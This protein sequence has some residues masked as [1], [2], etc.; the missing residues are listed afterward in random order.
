MSH[1]KTAPGSPTVLRSSADDIANYQKKLGHSWLFKLSF[2]RSPARND[3]HVK[4]YSH[5]MQQGTGK[6][7]EQETTSVITAVIEIMCQIPTTVLK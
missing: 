1:H 6:A 2:K 3:L 7:L 4:K 5:S